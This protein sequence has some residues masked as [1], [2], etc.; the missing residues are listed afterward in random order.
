MYYGHTVRPWSRDR[1]ALFSFYLFAVS[2]CDRPE[3]SPRAYSEKGSCDNI[4]LHRSLLTHVHCETWRIGPFR[5]V[6]WHARLIKNERE[7]WWRSTKCPINFFKSIFLTMAKS[8][9]YL[10]SCSAELIR[11]LR[12]REITGGL[13][14]CTNLWQLPGIAAT[15]RLE[16]KGFSTVC[17]VVSPVTDRWSFRS[18]FH[19]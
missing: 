8:I 3:L 2:A 7:F 5:I 9:R 19:R 18:D 17:I 13:S 10:I 14:I 11:N 1:S 16:L 12:L 6:N 4:A 15:S